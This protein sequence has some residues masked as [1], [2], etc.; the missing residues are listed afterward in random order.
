[1]NRQNPSEILS[2]AKLWRHPATHA[3]QSA[4]TLP[5]LTD[6]GADVWLCPLMSDALGSAGP[7]ADTMSSVLAADAQFSSFLSSDE[8]DRARNFF[9]ESKA[10]EFLAARGWLRLLLARYVAETEPKFIR[11]GIAEGGKPYLSDYAN[12]QFNLSHSGEFVVIAVS[13][14]PVGV[15]IERLRPLPDWRSLADG[16]LT[17][18]AIARIA[19]MPEAERDTGF[20]R[21]FTAREA[22]LKATGSGFSESTMM[23][24]QEFHSIAMENHSYGPTWPLPE[25]PGYVGQLCLLPRSPVDANQENL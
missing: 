18:I 23:L 4:A 11:L 24:E 25:I 6:N 9:P 15:D 7:A 21:Q 20:L 2:K 19:E 10:G 17:N 8:T 13:N 1:M 22:Y 3:W 14:H 16:L 12:L 5:E